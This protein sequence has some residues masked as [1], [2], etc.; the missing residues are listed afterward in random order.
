MIDEWDKQESIWKK[1]AIAYDFPFLK[2]ETILVL[3]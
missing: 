3:N 2:V 1:S